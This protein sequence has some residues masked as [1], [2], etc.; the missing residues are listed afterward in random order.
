MT[1]GFFTD[2]LIKG[3]SGIVIVGTGVFGGL[4]QKSKKSSTSELRSHMVTLTMFN[5]RE[6]PKVQMQ[7]LKRSDQ[8][9]KQDLSWFR[10]VLEWPLS[11]T[12]SFLR[13]TLF[14][15]ISS[16]KNPHSTLLLKE[17]LQTHRLFMFFIGSKMYEIQHLIQSLASLPDRI[18]NRQIFHDFFMPK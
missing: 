8:L 6:L 14:S 13:I 18:A 5:S 3:I 10:P 4:S 17:L 11:E 2:R 15:L 16:L 1:I 9:T 12:C 7:I